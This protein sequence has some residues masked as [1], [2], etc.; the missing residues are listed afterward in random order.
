MIRLEYNEIIGYHLS[1]TKRRSEL[2]K[3]QLIGK[4]KL[5]LQINNTKYKV[6]PKELIL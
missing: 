6:K 3:K 1:L 4:S 2:L 5:L